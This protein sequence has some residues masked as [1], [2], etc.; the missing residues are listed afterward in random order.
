MANYLKADIGRAS[1]NALSR[2][3]DLSDLREKGLIP[4]NYSEDTDVELA[5]ARFDII[6][7]LQEDEEFRSILNLAKS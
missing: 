2:I 6:K 1:L 7:R 5:E 4:S 3:S